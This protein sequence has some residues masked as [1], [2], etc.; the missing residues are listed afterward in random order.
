LGT[1]RGEFRTDDD[2][3]ALWP[4][5]TNNTCLP[6]DNPAEPCT[7]GFYGTYVIMA[8]KEEHIKVGVDFARER[9]LRLIIRNTGHDFLGRSTGYESLVINT[10]SFRDVQFVKQYAGPGNW[11]GPAAVVGAGVQ[12]RE[13]FRQAWNQEPKQAIVGGECPV[14]DGLCWESA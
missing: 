1:D 6:T 11:T 2:I 14:C 13:L 7:Q 8:T 9:N 10:H 3:A 12:G 5:Y 4:L